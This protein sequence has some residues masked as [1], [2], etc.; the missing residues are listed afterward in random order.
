MTG[1]RIV[2]L[3]PP[4]AGKGTQAELVAAALNVPHIS[5]GEMF[6]DAVASGSELGRRAQE[7]MEAGD[8]V[9]DDLTSALVAER[10]AAPD[11]EC[12]YLLD[13]FP[14]TGAQA[15]A[16]DAMAGGTVDTVML[17]EVD[18]EELVRRLLKRAA[19]S[20]RSDDNEVTIRR[21]L[22]VYRDLTEPLVRL[23]ESRG[24]LRRFDGVGTVEEVFARL[25][26]GLAR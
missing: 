6:R 24:L 23:Y 5:T 10:I 1:R 18:E 19:E 17:V 20:G 25:M 21:R 2:F 14:R 13:G 15:E 26:L 7:I 11:A 22:E 9:P 3:G 4:G 16:L 8:L 12:G